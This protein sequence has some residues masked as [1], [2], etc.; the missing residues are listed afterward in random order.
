VNVVGLRLK[1]LMFASVLVIVGIALFFY[2]TSMS[3][4]VMK[5]DSLI[6]GTYLVVLGIFLA[7]AGFLVLASQIF[8]GHSILY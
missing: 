4:Y 7:I 3:K 1:T 5:P 6:S 8:R 2:G